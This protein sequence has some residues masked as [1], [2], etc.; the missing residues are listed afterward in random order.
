LLTSRAQG[1]V[2]R[3]PP[4]VNAALSTALNT[5]ANGAGAAARGLSM[6]EAVHRGRVPRL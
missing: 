5:A 1:R 4:P 3:M 2:A 6:V